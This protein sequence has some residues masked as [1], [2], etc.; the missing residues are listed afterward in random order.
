MIEKTL[1]I[2]AAV[3]GTG[4]GLQLLYLGYEKR[5]RGAES[6][7]AELDADAKEDAIRD[8]K[9]KQAYDRIVQLQDIIDW[10]RDKWVALADEAREL[11]IELLQE[12]EA[13]RFA[14]R[15]KCSVEGCEK[16]QPP[17]IKIVE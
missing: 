2:L 3:F 6:K 13:R 8:A 9:L 15:D 11:K 14:E 5:R 17:R 10:E 16:R 1:A 7:I 4:W 12:K